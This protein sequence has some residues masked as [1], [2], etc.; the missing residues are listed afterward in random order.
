MYHGFIDVPTFAYFDFGNVWIGSLLNDL[1]YKIS[2]LKKNEP[3]VLRTEIWHGREC[4]EL[5]EN[6]ESFDNEFSEQ[7]YEKTLEELNSRIA[8]YKKTL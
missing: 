4:F 5:A 2:P 6:I 1:N 7:G 3:P 8:E